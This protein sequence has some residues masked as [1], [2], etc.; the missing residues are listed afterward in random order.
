MSRWAT[1][2]GSGPPSRQH[3][4]R[5]PGTST[6]YPVAGFD[7]TF[8]VPKSV[9]VLWAL[10]PQDVRDQVFAAHHRAVQ[11]TL[12]W[13]ECRA[14]GTRTGRN[15]VA[16]VPVRGAIAAAFDHWESRAGDPQLHTH[17]VIANRVQRTSDGA[18]ATLDSRTLYKAVV[19]ASE[20]YNGLLFD[21]LRRSLGTETEL[22]APA[23]VER[24]P[25][26][27]LSGVDAGLITEFSTR[28]RIIE[29]EKDRLV[30]LWN[31][32]HGTNPSDATVLKLRQQATLST[33]TAKD[34]QPVPLTE[35][36]T[37]WRRR[38]EGLGCRPERLTCRHRRPVP[39]PAPHAVRTCPRNGGRS[40]G[41]WSW[42]WSPKNAP[43]G[44]GGICSPRPNA[45]APA[46]GWPAPPNAQR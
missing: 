44:T 2:T 25:S 5:K 10:S 18:W 1:D 6:R 29:L 37:S 43:P 27:E 13:L 15:G 41:S 46:S 45:S 35:R 32:E 19:A 17:L 31:L 42:T 4:G 38:A 22:R 26:R 16:H 28:A 34:A 39:H 20:H 40:P 36:L 3:S 14:I 7:L 8:S 12:V 9:S 24:N 30:R 11:D 21:E 23:S 33:R